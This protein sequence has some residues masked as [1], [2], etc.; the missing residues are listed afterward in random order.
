MAV[1]DA[2]TVDAGNRALRSGIQAVVLEILVVVVPML[3][4]ALSDEN[5]DPSW[6]WL[7]SLGRIAGMAALAYVMR[8]FVDPSRIPTPLPPTPVPPPADP[9]PLGR[10][11]A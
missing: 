3:I 11:P 8:A 10:Y 2:L 4:S 1:S 5:W 9:D 6:S 7:E